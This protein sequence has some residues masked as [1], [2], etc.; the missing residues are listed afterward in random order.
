MERKSS[1]SDGKKIFAAA[2]KPLETK[3]DGST[4]N[5]AIF[6]K[7]VQHHVE[8]EGWNPLVTI[9]DQQAANPTNRNLLLEHRQLTLENVRANAQVYVA[10]N[11]HSKQDS[12]MFYT[13]LQ[14]LLMKDARKQLVTEKQQ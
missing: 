7:D 6:I 1:I 14:D 11:D 2:T 10:A 8:R 9:S 4:E 13:F 5:L 3:Y 12:Y